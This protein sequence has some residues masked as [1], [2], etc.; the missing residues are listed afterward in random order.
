MVVGTLV[1]CSFGETADEQV[2]S[3][4]RLFESFCSSCHSGDAPQG[5]F[6][7][8]KLLETPALDGKLAFEHLITR[9]MPPADAD[10]P[11]Q[12]ER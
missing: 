5:T 8:E 4:T 6:N 12:Q 1:R 3:T 9:R 10:Q 11:S 2:H 7:I